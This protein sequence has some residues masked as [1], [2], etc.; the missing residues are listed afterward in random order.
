MFCLFL[1]VLWVVLQCLIVAV[2]D[3]T[4]LPFRLTFSI[5]FLEISISPTLL[6]LEW[7]IG[8]GIASF[9]TSLLLN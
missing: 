8:D 2:H 7:L 1:T 3:R 6:F 5:Q 9:Q 4:H